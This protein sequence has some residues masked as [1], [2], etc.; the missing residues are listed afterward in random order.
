[1][2]NFDEELE[3]VDKEVIEVL[4]TEPFKSFMLRI[5]EYIGRYTKLLR[6]EEANGCFTSK[7]EFEQEYFPKE[8]NQEYK[9]GEE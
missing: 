7:Y 5:D 3:R 6:F 1:M 9:E 8:T 4:E 2:D